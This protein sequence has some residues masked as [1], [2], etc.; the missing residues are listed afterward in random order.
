MKEKRLGSKILIIL[1][2][3]A[4]LLYFGLQVVGYFGDPLR[5]AMAYTYRVEESTELAGVIIRNEMVLEDDANGL[6]QL[7]RDEGERVSRSGIIASVYADQ[8]A[9][10]QHREIEAAEL[11]V[12]Q[13][14][15]ARDVAV[16]AEASVKLDA[17]ILRNMRAVRCATEENHLAAVSEYSGEL[18]ALVLKRDYN[19]DDAV[20]L[21][22]QLKAAR[23]ELK[24]LK[25]QVTKSTRRI[26]APRAGLYSAVVDGYEKILTPEVVEGMKPLSAGGVEACP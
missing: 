22:A 23:Q 25:T 6:L 2:A 11:R 4:V 15:Y 14:E 24:Q 21:D 8:A 20:D 17:Q 7:H 18:R 12:Q 1:L 3:L 16:G 26:R 19:P 5:T 9:M 10:D 13:L